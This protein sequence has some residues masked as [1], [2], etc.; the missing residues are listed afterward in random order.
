MFEQYETTEAQEEV[1][2]ELTSTS[3]A[4]KSTTKI[5]FKH[6]DE[7][8]DSNRPTKDQNNS[9][10]SGQRKYCQYCAY[11][12][13]SYITVHLYDKLNCRD[14]KFKVRKYHHTQR[15]KTKEIFIVVTNL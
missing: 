8:K 13:K 3:I 9:K 12:G 6:K 11:K 1:R 14:K 5:T 15:K 4:N 2:K 7:T 10:G